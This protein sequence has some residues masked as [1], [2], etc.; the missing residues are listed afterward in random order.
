MCEATGTEEDGSEI[1]ADFSPES[2]RAAYQP[3]H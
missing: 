2:F 1:A 3:G